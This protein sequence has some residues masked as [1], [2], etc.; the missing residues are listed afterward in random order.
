MKIVYPYYIRIVKFA[1]KDREIMEKRY[2]PKST[3]FMAIEDFTVLNAPLYRTQSITKWGTGS[4]RIV[5]K[6]K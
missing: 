3:N 4:F 1:G 5:R 2:V 6:Q